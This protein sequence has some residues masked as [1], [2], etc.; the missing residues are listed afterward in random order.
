MEWF[1]DSQ[2]I[3]SRTSSPSSLNRPD[4]LRVHGQAVAAKAGRP[5]VYLE[6]SGGLRMDEQARTM[7]R[8]DGIS[9]G[10]ICVFSRIEPC[11]TDRFV[12][13]KP[14][15]RLVSAQ[16]KCL[17]LYFY[18]LDREFGLMHVKIQNWSSVGRRAG[19]PETPWQSA[20]PRWTSSGASSAAPPRRWRGSS[21]AR[22]LAADAVGAAWTSR[23]ASVGSA[24][25]GRWCGEAGR[26]APHGPLTNV[27]GRLAAR[28]LR[29]DRDSTRRS[30][31]WSS[32]HCASPSRVDLLPGSSE[33]PLS[34]IWH[35]ASRRG[36][37]AALSTLGS[38]AMLRG[39]TD[40]PRPDG[41]GRKS[42]VDF[43]HA[44]RASRL[45]G[46]ALQRTSRIEF[47]RRRRRT[48]SPPW[49]RRSRREH[50]LRPRARDPV[51]IS[52]PNEVC[53][54]DA[55]LRVIGALR[56]RRSP[57]WS[58]FRPRRVPLR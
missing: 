32:P 28:S 20:A 58:V 16:R 18:F 30:R 26:R 46:G 38:E 14:K 4:A 41:D 42:S 40:R 57:G 11:R 56:F 9:R 51:S 54:V 49:P 24:S 50:E 22:P 27:L 15:P 47:G 29:L 53:L 36:F 23:R 34:A 5:Y 3:C 17:H 1:L 35:A 33:V 44:Q 19:P 12:Y 21:F 10:L 2:G 45:R 52:D 8:K 25:S 39:V 43:Y 48:R 6:S 31:A 55:I 37:G 13:A 7:A